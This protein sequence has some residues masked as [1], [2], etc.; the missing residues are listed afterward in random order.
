MET[1]MLTF[2]AEWLILPKEQFRILV[3]L[4]DVGAFRGSLADMCRYFSVDPQ[5][6]NNNRLRAAID[7]LTRHHYITVTQT[8]RTYEMAVIPKE[9]EITMPSEWVLRILRHEYNS[10]GVA[11]ENVLKVQLWLMQN[12]KELVTNEDISL[13][14]GISISQVVAA[15]NVLKNE[16]Q[17]FIK[18]YAYWDFD[19]CFRRK[20]QIID[21]SA[22]WA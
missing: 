11:W 18:E 9:T 20:G 15:M 16:F 22:W 2:F 17:A 6:H 19:N 5:T 8:G 4:A 7:E 12:S 1:Q 21:L 13:D 3:M 14:V 10:E